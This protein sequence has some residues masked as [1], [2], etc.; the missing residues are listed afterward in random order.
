MIRTAAVIGAGAVGSF[1]MSELSTAAALSAGSDTERK[2][3]GYDLEVWAVASGER[4]KRLEDKGLVLN[5]SPFLFSVRMPEESKGADLII[6]CV[7]YGALQQALQDARIIADHHTIFLCPM[8]GVDTEELLAQYMGKGHILHS[9]MVIAA[10]RQGNQVMYH[11]GAVPC[12][13]YGLVNSYGA[14]EDL[15]QV[16][17]L[18]TRTGLNSKY[19]ETI[20]TTIWNKFALNISTNIAQAITG[21]NYGSY[22]ASFY[23]NELGQHLCDEVLAVAR[24]KGITCT[25]DNQ[26]ALKT[27]PTS[28]EARFSTLQDL[29]AGRHTEVDLF[30]GAVMRMGKE[31]GVPTPYNEFAYLVIK[32]LEE[33][34]EGL[35]R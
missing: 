14:E 17:E 30:C 28:E 5:G 35:I 8:N 7:K 18:F 6:I 13:H 27:I 10:E 1:F 24:A 23:M 9:M 21:T 19:S 33:K 22:K 20:I 31:C 3:T 12:V 25:F 26:R 2:R 16:R 11:S 34:N 15:E 29:M 32:A 4:K